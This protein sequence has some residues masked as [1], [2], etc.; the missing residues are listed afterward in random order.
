MFDKLSVR[1]KSLRECAFGMELVWSDCRRSLKPVHSDACIV[2]VMDAVT[3]GTP[4]ASHGVCSGRRVLVTHDAD[5]TACRRTA[6]FS[7]HIRGSRAAVETFLRSSHSAA[8]CPGVLRGAFTDGRTVS[9]VCLHGDSG[10]C[11]CSEEEPFLV[12]AC[13]VPPTGFRTLFALLHGPPCELTSR[14][15]PPHPRLGCGGSSDVF[16]VTV[17]GV[18]M[19]RKVARDASASTSAQFATER[20][21][22]SLFRDMHTWFPQLAD[23]QPDNGALDFVHP[24]RAVPLVSHVLVC[25]PTSRRC[26][27]NQTVCRL[28]TILQVGTYLR[29]R[30][31]FAFSFFFAYAYAF[32]LA[33]A[34]QIAHGK[35]WVHGD[36][37]PRNMVVNEDTVV[38]LVIN[39]HMI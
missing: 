36:V 9:F 38:Y 25:T 10:E 19:V 22:L 28:L 12:R 31:F 1:E 8:P 16:R 3:R 26:F 35:G 29:V 4:W 14:P 21:V 18:P 11:V 2:H 32:P 24:V 27:A 17:H 15:P 13:K 34:S 39:M 30:V 5:T 7:L 20:R 23:E 6:V 33:F 37:R